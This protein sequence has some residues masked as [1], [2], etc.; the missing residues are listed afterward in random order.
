MLLNHWADNNIPVAV[1]KRGVAINTE[2]M[3][4]KGTVNDYGRPM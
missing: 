4:P 2:L 1:E 3:L